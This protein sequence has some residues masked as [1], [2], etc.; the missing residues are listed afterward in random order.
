[1]MNTII[2]TQQL[3]FFGNSMEKTYILDLC[4]FRGTW[5]CLIV[6]WIQDPSLVNVL[7]FNGECI[8]VGENPLVS[9]LNTHKLFQI[10]KKKFL[11]FLFCLN[12]RLECLGSIILIFHCTRWSSFAT[13][14][15]S[16]NKWLWVSLDSKGKNKWMKNSTQRMFS[17]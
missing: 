9:F 5:N 1:M 8:Y 13:G 14:W 16:S 7:P 4:V 6:K 17:A 3:I 15:I 10:L 2:A 12:C 11:I